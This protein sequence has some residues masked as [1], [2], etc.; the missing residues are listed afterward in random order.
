[1]NNVREFPQQ[2]ACFDQ[3]SDWIA[4]FDKGLS[5]TEEDEF[6]AWLSESDENHTVFMDMAKLWDQMDTLSRLAD[7]CPDAAKSSSSLQRYSW[8]IAASVFLAIAVATWSY[9]DTVVRESPTATVTMAS[10]SVYETAIG[11]QSTFRLMDGTQIMLN[12]NSRVSV[13]FTTNNRFLYLERGEMHVSVAHDRS[14]RLSVIVGGRVVQAV[15]TE[16]NIEIT[17]ENSIELVVTE[18]VVMVGILEH[19]IDETASQEPLILTPSAALV[20]AGQEVVIDSTDD[21]L[22]AVVAEDIDSGEIAV[23]LSWRQGNLIFRGE[24]LEDAVLE[25]G[26]YTEVQF[27]FLDEESKKIRVAGLF[28]AGDVDGLLTALRQNFNIS[29]EWVADDKIVLSGQ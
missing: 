2:N 6:K 12:T 24:S 7:I 14:R 19:P 23:K 20:S 4:K 5:A 15:G 1:M 21:A 11:E 9:F 29:Y 13:N 16:F 8:S 25:I 17:G 3:A 26:R 10:K 18:G 27:V 22:E 28:K